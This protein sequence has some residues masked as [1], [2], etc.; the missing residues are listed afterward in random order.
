MTHC[1]KNG[2]PKLVSELSLPLTGLSCVRKIVSDLAV[3][4]INSEGFLIT[5]VAPGIEPSEVLKQTQG[6]VKISSSVREISL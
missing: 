6:R 3:L 1:S 4:E 2:Q 5:E